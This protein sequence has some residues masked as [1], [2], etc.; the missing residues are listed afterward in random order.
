L[1]VKNRYGCTAK[2]SLR[3]ITFCKNSQVF[4]PNAFTP[5]GDGVN[6]MLMV[7]GEG[8]SVKSFR[9]FN[10]WGNL[11]FEKVNFAPNDPTYGWNGKVK[12][13]AAAP[14][15]YVYI[16]EVTCDNGTVYFH[17]GNT[18]LLK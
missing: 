6:D 13:I 5:D 3:V 2:D 12:G 14:D 8:I 16:A 18:T 15:V 1:T 11:V 9:I 4:V 17:K 7:R 10:R